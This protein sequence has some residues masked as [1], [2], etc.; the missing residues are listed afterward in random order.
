[1]TNKRA[2]PIGSA[3]PARRR[4][5]SATCERAGERGM[6]LMIML[7]VLVL[8]FGAGAAIHNAV[9]GET[10]LRGVH[11]RSTAAFYAAEAAL[12]RGMGDF[13]NIFLSYNVPTDFGPQLF[14]VGRHAVHY[15]LNPVPGNPRVLLVPAGKQ[16]AG[17]NAIEY[18]YTATSVSQAS[19]G[20]S[21]ASVGSEFDVDY[22]PLFQFLAFY[23]G[24]LEILP[25]PVM[26]LHGPIHTNG[27]LYLGAD[28]TLTIADLQ[29][30]IP[31]VHISAAGDLF[32]GRKDKPECHATVKVGRL[33]DANHDGALDLQDV[34]CSGVVS[35]AQIATWL[36]AIRV[37]QPPVTVPSP[38]TI[39]RGT[40]T[41]WTQADLR[42]VLDLDAPDALGHYPIVVQTADG[43]IDAAKTAR[44]QQFMI[45]RPGRLFYNDVPLAGH[46]LNTACTSADSYCNPTSYAPAFTLPALVYPCAGSDL[47]LFGACLSTILNEPLTTGGVTARRGG[48]YNNRERTWVWM[49]DLNLHDLLEWNRNQ[50]GANRLFDPA[51]R[52]DGGLVIFLS[53][54]GG[55]SNGIPSP[56]YGVRVFGSPQLYFPAAA[57][58]TGVTVASDQAAYVEGD[59][60]VGD[61]TE[62]KQPA[63][64]IGDTINILSRNWSSVVACRND[65]Q[66]RQGLGARPATSTTVYAAFIGGV[67]V[68][69]PGN[70]NGGLENYPRFHEDWSGQT[71]TYRGSFV[72]FG[73][74]QHNNGPWCGTGG[75]CNIYNP[76]ARNWDFDAA[77]MQAENLPPLTPRLVAVAQTFFTE[78]FR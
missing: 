29:P 26:T 23:A 59:Y 12:N 1:M 11:A 66:S 51:D 61:A 77:F 8:L 67:D 72:S 74:P 60:N 22:I 3:A 4:A 45:D 47:A 41:F 48:F 6:A 63:A 71:L 55:G 31:T 78:N 13:R 21:E 46:D 65:C 43:A 35:D 7:W 34:P 56:R 5:N 42:I 49:L 57:D 10:K 27:T 2:M 40:G 69:V 28:N 19:N 68:T 75:G 16:F 54:K 20:D 33:V 25:G 73:P 15:Q 44:L 53:V 76:P 9:I 39:A 64:I 18:R 17:L 24:D 38:D 14:D 36:G 30:T 37:H 32:R 58:P 62:P 70:Y 50:V 52:S